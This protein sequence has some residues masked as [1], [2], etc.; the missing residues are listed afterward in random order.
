MMDDKHNLIDW[1]IN[2]RRSTL[3]VLIFLLISGTFAYQ[4]IPKESEPDIAI[5]IIYVSMYH[6]GIS[7]ADAERLLVRPMEKE[8]KSIEGV[9]EMRSSAGESHA[10]VTLEFDAGFDS[11]SALDD[12]REKVD[13]A[14]VNLPTDTE[15][16]EVNE[17]NVALFP[18]LSMSLSGSIQERN[19]LRI[20]RDLRDDIEALPGV[21]EVDIGGDREEVLEIIVDPLVLETY[22]IDFESVLNIVNRNNQL[23][24][25]GAIDSGHGRQVM[26]VS[27]VIESLDDILSLPIKVVGDTV[28]SFRDV[29]TVRRAFKDPQSFARVNGE[30]A[31]S[32]DVKKR[33]GSNIIE[34]IGQ[35]KQIVDEK[36]QFWPSSLK[37][38]YTIDKSGQIVDML[39]DLQNNVSSAIVMVMIV[40]VGALGLRSSL[41]VG[42]AIPASFLT[43][44]LII[45]SMGYTL[46][47]VVLFS[48]ILVVGM[49][50][51]G[52]IVVTELASRNQEQGLA[53][54]KAFSQASK[55]MAWPI[56]ASTATTLVVFLPLIAWPGTVGEF[57]KFLPITVIIC[58]LASLAVALVFL[59]VLGSWLGGSRSQ[60]K[61]SSESTQSLLMSG[62]MRLLGA[63]LRHPGKTLLLAM[64]IIV[65]TYI[66][67]AQ[68]GKG[69]EFFPDVEPET[70]QVL[71]HARGDLSIYEK[72]RLLKEVEQRL[73]GMSELK[74]LYARS[75]NRSQG[76]VAEDVIGS[77]QF[78][79]VDWQGRRVASEILNEMQAKTSDLAGI[80]LEFRKE[81]NGPSG[82][83]PI[84]LQVGAMMPE[85]LQEAVVT[86]RK[87]MTELGGFKDVEDNRPLPGIEWRLEVDREVSARYG[88]DI[89]LIGSAIQMI[90][91]GYRVSDYRPDDSDEEIDISIRFPR[92]E[93]TLDKFD[94]FS[95]QTEKGMIPLSNFVTLI[96]AQKT[97]NIKRVDGK[98][99]ITIQ[100]DVE[101]GRLV[102]ERLQSLQELM[103]TRELKPDVNI[104]V[105]GE[106][107]DQR[108][109]AQFLSSA[110]V[111]AIFLMLLILVTQF[112]SFY[113]SLLVLSAIVF[114]TAGVLIGL[115]VTAQ[116]FGVVMVG[117]GIIA[118]AG[119]VVNNN[120]V[121]IDT[122]N[123]YLKE[124]LSPYDSALIT[125]ELRMRPVLL[126]AGTTILG[127]IPMVLSMNIDFIN[128]DVT[129]GA[130]STQWWTQL[131]S[132]IAG[133]LAFATLLT[134]FLTPCLLVLGANVSAY[135]KRKFAKESELGAEVRSDL[136]VGTT[137][138]LEKKGQKDLTP[139]NE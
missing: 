117:L 16:P 133:G 101:E 86:I 95:I 54:G 7:P 121:L 91:N 96:P 3:L 81:E 103:K 14:K 19:L 66:A 15:E 38:T 29:A 63:L 56:I 89:A 67:Y 57:M 40:I 126:T 12:V 8:L 127:L 18:V 32:L 90:T 11:Q 116:P 42:V 98:R 109:T 123:A 111:L 114:S 27:G 97:G 39:K 25:A 36:Q 78:Q 124:G 115:M 108:E 93:R 135:F 74:S 28:V 99:V 70:A 69:V 52:A 41:L 20:A 72:D 112:N 26:K 113:Q 131:S 2:R 84:Q 120:I 134:L 53:A 49:L 21:L 87:A 122:Y 45:Y 80:K 110:F 60:A 119:I 138:G 1:A 136:M 35:V 51:D 9:K 34:V 62:Y 85:H 46:N 23:V 132:A 92:K 50:V 73:Y 104:T 31:I 83:K 88:A 65:V 37:H 82:G 105:K 30:P 10:S 44:I 77:I 61:P 76:G 48:L 5:P 100:A 59:P 75:F 118:L 6:D 139:V 43:G 125:G 130:P 13:R 128:R 102:S 47:I 33:V 94:N 4:S 129:F 79:F 71:V 106:D 24:A 64:S 22:N 68:F 137:V 107:E 58:L 55:R 17:V